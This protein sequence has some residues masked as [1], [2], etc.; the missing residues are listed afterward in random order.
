MGGR[1]A[2]SLCGGRVGPLGRHDIAARQRGDVG[3]WPFS[4]VATGFGNIWCWGC[5]GS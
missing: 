1:L 4:E 3:Y 2:L 5:T